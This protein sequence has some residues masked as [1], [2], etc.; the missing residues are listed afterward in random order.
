MVGYYGPFT[1]CFWG[2]IVAVPGFLI[3]G[4]FYDFFDSRRWGIG[5][6]IRSGRFVAFIPRF[7]QSLYRDTCIRIGLGVESWGFLVGMFLTVFMFL[8]L[9]MLSPVVCLWCFLD[10]AFVFR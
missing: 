7:P 8:P 6:D 1:E 9:R 2:F 4:G 10:C 5:G 3:V